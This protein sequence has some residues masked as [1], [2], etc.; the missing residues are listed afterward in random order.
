MKQ[1]FK[2]QTNSSVPQ[3]LTAQWLMCPRECI[4]AQ[5]HGS[6][7][8]EVLSWFH[9]SLTLMF[10]GDNLTTKQIL[11]GLHKDSG[12]RDNTVHC[13]ALASSPWYWFAETI[14]RTRLLF[15]G[16]ATHF[17]LAPRN[18]ALLTLDRVRSIVSE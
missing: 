14:G 4:L 5:S 1:P 16:E 9:I 8:C 10:T 2:N 6:S 7:A 3:Q 15:P 13:V 18:A 11:A 12:R 17:L